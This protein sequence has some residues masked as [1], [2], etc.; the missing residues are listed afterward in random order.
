MAW[1]Y[2][3]NPPDLVGA[4]NLPPEPE[5]SP[6][7]LGALARARGV[8][9][10]RLP[11]MLNGGLVQQPQGSGGLVRPQSQNRFVRGIDKVV[12]HP[13]FK[14]LL[15]GVASGIAGDPTAGARMAAASQPSITDELN[16][17]RM[18][19]MQRAEADASQTEERKQ[20]LSEMLQAGDTEGARA[21]AAELFPQ[22][23][24]GELFRAPPVTPKFSPITVKIGER[25]AQD[26]YP[27]PDNSGPD[28]QR[29]LGKPYD[30]RN[31][32]RPEGSEV[33][34]G[35]DGNP[36]Y[37]KGGAALKLTGPQ[38][39]RAG[40]RSSRSSSVSDAMSLYPIIKANPALQARSGVAQPIARAAGV[41]SPSSAGSVRKWLTNDATP[42]QQ[43][44]YNRVTEAAAGVATHIINKG[45]TTEPDIA[46]A[47]NMLSQ[48]SDPETYQSALR[49]TIIMTI[50]SDNY[51]ARDTGEQ[52][53]YDI[54]KDEDM[55]RLKAELQRQGFTD[56]EILDIG[57]AIVAP[58]PRWLQ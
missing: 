35:P 46:R 1:P 57:K 32:P 16:R 10:R 45:A 24:A 54:R 38:V 51:D 56:D 6:Q 34:M 42:D 44:L 23:A 26:Y 11:P 37:A 48:S 22:T 5:L 52:P 39:A 43:A 58:M 47:K 28:M 25:Q 7:E 55:L 8:Q 17:M 21:V 36:I 49:D 18:R 20:K 3:N 13:L 29:P 14:S 41:L 30:V 50:R 15:Q 4:L 33:V 53:D 40:E 19:Q 12:T 27:L 2:D 9:P 31:P